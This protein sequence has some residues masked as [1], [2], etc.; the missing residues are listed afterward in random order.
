MPCA[1]VDSA[2]RNGNAKKTQSP[3]ISRAYSHIRKIQSMLGV[4]AIKRTKA[5][6]RGWGVSGRGRK[7]MVY[8]MNVVQWPFLRK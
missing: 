7:C 1:P 8:V 3:C 4:G 2:D 5:E 6:I